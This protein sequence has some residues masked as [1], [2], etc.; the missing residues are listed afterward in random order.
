[1]ITYEPD[2]ASLAKRGILF[3]DGKIIGDQVKSFWPSPRRIHPQMRNICVTRNTQLFAKARVKNETW[4][5]STLI[6][7][8]KHGTPSHRLILRTEVG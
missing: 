2:I 5:D 1:M 6:V 3:R 7:W 4:F 8:S